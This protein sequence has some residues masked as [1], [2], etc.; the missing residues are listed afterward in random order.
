[1]AGCRR[2]RHRFPPPGSM[3]GRIVVIPP[4]RVGSEVLGTL[5]TA[6]PSL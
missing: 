4:D 6:R 5:G 3:A 1:M 2:S